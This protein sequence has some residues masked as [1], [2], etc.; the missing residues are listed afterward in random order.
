[1]N[2]MYTLK[3][4]D[5]TMY[6]QTFDQLVYASNIIVSNVLTPP[7]YLSPNVVSSNTITFENVTVRCSHPSENIQ[8]LVQPNKESIV[9]I[10]ASG[11]GTDGN[12]GDDGWF[13]GR[14]PNHGWGP[15][16]YSTDPT[17]GRKSYQFTS[18]IG[19]SP[20]VY[21][22]PLQTD[23]VNGV[24]GVHF[25][26]DFGRPLSMKSS[27]F[28][29]PS[30]KVQIPVFSPRQVFF[31]TSDT[32]SP[33][34]NWTFVHTERYEYPFPNNISF[35]GGYTF[36]DHEYIFPAVYTG[37]YWRAVIAEA[38]T[39][40]LFIHSIQF[41][42]DYTLSNAIQLS[43][44]NVY[45]PLHG[46]L[47]EPG[48][49]VNGKWYLQSNEYLVNS[50]VTLDPYTPF[51][52]NS[53]MV[54]FECSLDAP[55][56]L[57][58]GQLYTNGPMTLRFTS[59]DF[60]QSEYIAPQQ[61]IINDFTPLLYSEVTLNTGIVQ[62]TYPNVLAEYFKNNFNTRV[63][64]IIPTTN[65]IYTLLSDLTTVY[66][67]HYIEFQYGSTVTIGSYT[68]PETDSLVLLKSMNGT[69][70]SFD[71]W[72]NT[73]WT[74][75]V[76]TFSIGSPPYH[77]IV[78][79]KPFDLTL[80]QFDNVTNPELV[81][82]SKISSLRTNEYTLSIENI[83]PC[84]IPSL[85]Q[86]GA[87]SFTTQMFTEFDAKFTFQTPTTLSFIDIY[88]NN[89]VTS[90]KTY[91]FVNNYVGET[92]YTNG[93]EPL[94]PGVVSIYGSNTSF[95]T[96]DV[97]YEGAL[98]EDTT[99]RLSG[100]YNN[101]N[102]SF[103][104]STYTYWKVHIKPREQIELSLNPGGPYETSNAEQFNM[105]TFRLYRPFV[106]NNYDTVQVVASI[107]SD[108]VNIPVSKSTPLKITFGRDNQKLS[109]V[110]NGTEY[111]SGRVVTTQDISLTVPT[112]G[113]FIGRYISYTTY[114]QFTLDNQVWHVYNSD[115]TKTYTF[116]VK[117]Y[118]EQDETPMSMSNIFPNGFSFYMTF[119]LPYDTE[120]P[121]GFRIF[122]IRSENFLTNAY[123][124][125][126][127]LIKRL[128]AYNLVYSSN[129]YTTQISTNFSYQFDR[130]YEYTLRGTVTSEGISFQ[131]NDDV[132][133]YNE[134]SPALFTEPIVSD[135][136]MLMDPLPISDIHPV[137]YISHPETISIDLKR[138]L[139]IQSL[140]VI[141]TSNVQK[142]DYYTT[143][144]NRYINYTVDRIH[145]NVVGNV[146]WV[147]STNLTRIENKTT[148]PPLTIKEIV[149]YDSEFN[150]VRQS[151]TLGAPVN[152]SLPVSRIPTESLIVQNLNWTITTQSRPGY[153]FSDT[154]SY[155]PGVTY[156]KYNIEFSSFV[157]SS[158]S[159]ELASNSAY[160][161][162]FSGD[163]TISHS[164]DMELNIP[165]D[166]KTLFT[167][168]SSSNA[169]YFS[170][171]LQFYSLPTLFYELPDGTY[172]V[173]PFG[174][175]VDI[176]SQ[177]LKLYDEG[178]VTFYV[179]EYT[180][181]RWANGSYYSMTTG[182]FSPTIDAPIIVYQVPMKLGIVTYNVL[183][184]FTYSATTLGNTFKLKTN[185][186]YVYYNTQY[187]DFRFTTSTYVATQFRLSDTGVFSMAATKRRIGINSTNKLC[188]ANAQ[189]YPSFKL[190]KDGRITFNTFPG[191]RNFH[192]L[193]EVY[194]NIQVTPTI[195]ETQQPV[196]SLGTHIRYND[197]VVPIV[198][199]EGTAYTIEDGT[200]ATVDNITIG[201][202]E[203]IYFGLYYIS[204]GFVI[205][206]DPYFF[207]SIDD[208]I[209]SY[210]ISTT[211]TPYNIQSRQ[212]TTYRLYD[213]NNILWKTGVIDVYQPISG[214]WIQLAPENDRSNVSDMTFYGSYNMPS[215]S[216]SNTSVILNTNSIRLIVSGTEPT[217]VPSTDSV[218]DMH[219]YDIRYN[220]SYSST[221]DGIYTFTQPVVFDE[222]RGAQVVR[223][224]NDPTFQ[225]FIILDLP[226]T[227]TPF[228]YY[229]VKPTETPEFIRRTQYPVNTPWAPFN[230]HTNI[231]MDHSF[232]EDFPYTSRIR[233]EGLTPSS[234]VQTSNCVFT[235][236]D[237][238][239]GFHS[240]TLDVAAI[241]ATSFTAS[242]LM[243]FVPGDGVALGFTREKKFIEQGLTTTPLTSSEVVYTGYIVE[244]SISS[245]QKSVYVYTTNT[246]SYIETSDFPDVQAFTNVTQINSNVF[247]IYPTILA[248]NT[249]VISRGFVDHPD[250]SEISNGTKVFIQSN[251]F[252][253]TTYT[254]NDI[255]IDLAN[256]CYIP[257]TPITLPNF[258][259]D[260]ADAPY[261]IVL[262]E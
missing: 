243:S 152:L 173:Y 128:D 251:S 97:I 188:I 102:A 142:N 125:S 58:S 16:L 216:S 164:M 92:Y 50:I 212:K 48:G 129:G 57:P 40:I 41:R 169:L 37:R 54:T 166:V 220:T 1:M 18:N 108:T 105:C 183:D 84:D 5:G 21:S 55:D 8:Y 190:L 171:D 89:I 33:D 170:S 137:R 86:T 253:R 252:I 75:C 167:V 77:R 51:Q 64:R 207:T 196:T 187:D 163:G 160:Y 132:I 72:D 248:S 90:Y 2:R 198:S 47:F 176:P 115:P 140:D 179:N 186:G 258:T 242:N 185:E 112:V 159:S 11:F 79:R 120:I 123:G 6:S 154:Y 74:S 56:I 249:L 38:G 189:Y 214:S 168:Q 31:F 222:I 224:T 133:S 202:L 87:G 80:L 145:P 101:Y 181:I 201:Y 121:I 29:I 199:R 136:A 63:P 255:S 117:N 240:Y 218:F 98:S 113:P 76:R 155:T 49:Q 36:M 23:V 119:T 209:Y 139:D 81:S 62:T 66:Y 17:S 257:G 118:I 10:R 192:T 130:G 59:N 131:V 94:V 109:C 19:L 158:F 161:G 247:G 116:D 148:I 124:Q 180:Y 25:T 223:A 178:R 238:S 85:T 61:N 127:I 30:G 135:K 20:N 138:Y 250:Y 122:E 45:E 91:T 254:G 193:F 14:T 46:F 68:I 32:N 184:Y 200:N 232:V 78:F 219:V 42:G 27:Y 162:T 143:G 194:G 28:V 259:S 246:L 244:D 197:R 233:F 93:G 65:I 226:Y 9:S 217:F 22:A 104:P 114:P 7:Y 24:Y 96:M 211:C 177:H 26:Y 215:Y 71:V 231:F 236:S 60:T 262:T 53:M 241:D 237:T 174:Q 88:A 150:L 4:L 43:S 67:G 83:F 141:Q 245:I 134:L 34:T 182:L 203:N 213:T 239:N 261:K 229:K 230:I 204:T 100:V 206:N 256:T 73:A 157:Q 39:G 95:D 191:Y 225:T 235:V 153:T 175:E 82:S 221:V 99:K 165:G 195:V 107:N 70:W 208:D 69:V 146:Y 35:D 151:P 15:S 210:Q 126:I 227:D 111:M 106:Y 205:A 52:S 149:G 13:N 260:T 147:T 12:G 3:Q 103:T 234:N 172:R 144:I 156:Y 44:T 228:Q 110:V